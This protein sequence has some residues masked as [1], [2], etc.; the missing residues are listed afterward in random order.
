L[1]N[2]PLFTAKSTLVYL[3]K[4]TNA[5]YDALKFFKFNASSLFKATNPLSNYYYKF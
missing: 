2:L 5:L 4:L 3:I 1:T